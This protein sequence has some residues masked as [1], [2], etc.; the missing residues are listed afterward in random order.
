MMKPNKCVVVHF[1]NGT[2]QKKKFVF[3]RGNDWGKKYIILKDKKKLVKWIYLHLIFVNIPTACYLWVHNIHLLTYTRS[4]VKRWTNDRT[5]FEVKKK[6]IFYEI[7]I[8]IVHA[9][10]V[11]AKWNKLKWKKK[12][13]FTNE[14][15]FIRDKRET[16]GKRLT[17]TGLCVYVYRRVYERW[18]YYRV[19]KSFFFLNFFLN[20]ATREKDML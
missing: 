17:S 10:D 18:W 20:V 9:D 3:F 1:I 11:D 5:N 15:C 2:R 8:I 19:K 7:Y 12:K 16:R 6:K 13:I 14:R 4:T